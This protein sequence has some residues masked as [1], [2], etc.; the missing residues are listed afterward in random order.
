MIPVTCPSCKKVHKADESLIG[1]RVK[2]NDC[3][4]TFEVMSNEPQPVQRPD[5]GEAKQIAG[6]A[7]AAVGKA[8]RLVCQLRGSHGF[9]GRTLMVGSLLMLVSFFVPWWHITITP[10]NRGF[11]SDHES[12]QAFQSQIE[13]NAKR[14]V[15]YIGWY[16]AHTYVLNVE[17]VSDIKDMAEKG[18]KW[19]FRIWGWQCGAGYTSFILGLCII[20]ICGLTMAVAS[21]RGWGWISAMVAGAMGIPPFILAI[22]WV[23]SCPGIDIGDFV[24]QGVSAGPLIALPGAILVTVAGAVS[25]VT[26]LMKFAREFPVAIGVNADAKS[27][28]QHE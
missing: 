11:Q 23:V 1:K 15:K 19:S 26:G 2:C 28:E 16:N 27:A 21:V 3:G 10:S 9:F 7:L 20:G 14:L 5:A 12:A 25:G 6:A 13:N 24:Q 22:L 4:A 18:M 17:D 8:S